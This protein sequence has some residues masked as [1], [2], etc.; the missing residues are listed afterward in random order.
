MLRYASSFIL[1]KHLGDVGGVAV[2]SD[3]KF[4]QAFGKVK[5]CILLSRSCTL[6]DK[7]TDKLNKGSRSNADS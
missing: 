3:V 2:T 5:P 4:L 1:S 7:G 6:Q